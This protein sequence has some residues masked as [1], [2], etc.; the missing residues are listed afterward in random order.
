[1]KFTLITT[2][3]VLAT[4]NAKYDKF[5]PEQSVFDMPKTFKL[6]SD[7]NMQRKVVDDIQRFMRKQ[8]MP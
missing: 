2:A 8:G 6:R 4:A 5:E 1:M 3:L 7:P